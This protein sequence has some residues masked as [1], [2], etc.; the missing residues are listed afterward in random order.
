MDTKV[1]TRPEEALEEVREEQAEGKEEQTEGKEEQT[2]GKKEQTE[3]KKKKKKKD[4]DK[5][6]RGV[7]TMFRTTA[8]INIHLSRI[9]DEKAH[10]LLTINSIIISVLVSLVLRDIG[11]HQEYIIPSVL[12]MITSLVTFVLAI[13]VTMPL[14]THGTFKKEDVE[15]KT[16]N[17]LFFGNYHNMDME[18]YEWAMDEVIKDPDFVYGSMI[19]DNYHLGQVLDKKFKRLR[20][21]FWFFM[22]GF[23]ISVISFLLVDVFN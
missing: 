21:A 4:K 6:S 1:E 16:A 8:T 11:I 2:E 9:A 22:I 14:I 19:R 10:F 13:L 3:G 18:E 15:H 12:F 5:R 17:L 7:E 20:I 23:V